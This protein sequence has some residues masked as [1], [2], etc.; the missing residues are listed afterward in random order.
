MQML[1]KAMKAMKQKLRQNGK[2]RIAERR[3][4]NKQ[5]K[6]LAGGVT[7]TTVYDGSAKSYACSKHCKGKTVKDVYLD[8]VN[9]D[10]KG[11]A[12]KSDC[13]EIEIIE[14][15]LERK[16]KRKLL[17]SEK[18]KYLP[19]NKSAIKKGRALRKRFVHDH[20][21]IHLNKDISMMCYKD[22]DD[23]DTLYIIFVNRKEM[24]KIPIDDHLSYTRKYDPA[25]EIG[26]AAYIPLSRS[27]AESAYHYN[28]Y[29]DRE[30]D[31]KERAEYRKDLVNGYY[32]T[33]QIQDEIRSHNIYDYDYD[34][35]DVNVN[36]LM[37]WPN[38]ELKFDMT[39]NKKYHMDA[40]R[41]WLSSLWY[42]SKPPEWWRKLAKKRRQRVGDFTLNLITR[43][44]TLLGFKTIGL[45]DFA[46]STSGL[47]CSPSLAIVR[48]LQY[49]QALYEKHGFKD[50]KYLHGFTDYGGVKTRTKNALQRWA[51]KKICELPNQDQYTLQLIDCRTK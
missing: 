21:V 6:R 2:R 7:T 23:G 42:G 15:F 27:A 25:S 17:Q 26:L 43:V 44:A 30:W 38:F 11:V 4:V 1:H 33:E 40:D 13:H 51:S 16:T 39:T 31:H 41:L 36:T 14:K 10:R 12:S 29:G 28:E 34:A 18:I 35:G 46:H 22:E 24:D 19:L 48:T 45:Q 5:I 9:M 49:G 32:S 50:K 3:Q 37:L 20:H 47:L 8:K